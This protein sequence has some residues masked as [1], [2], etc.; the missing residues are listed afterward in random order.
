MQYR[1]PKMKGPR[2]RAHVTPLAGLLLG[3]EDSAAFVRAC[4]FAFHLRPALPLATVLAGAAVTGAGARP[5]ALALVDAGALDLFAGRL[6]RLAFTGVGGPRGEHRANR[7]NNQRTRN[8]I[9]HFI[10][11]W[12]EPFGLTSAISCCAACCLASR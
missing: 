10:L 6:G 11:L 4:L 5:V 7:G 12:L 3:D 9:L 2:R 1:S 8:S